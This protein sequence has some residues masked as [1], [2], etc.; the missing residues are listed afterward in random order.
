MTDIRTLKPFDGYIFKSFDVVDGF[1]YGYRNAHQY[2]RFGVDSDINTGNGWQ[3]TATFEALWN[4]DTGQ[5]L[6]STDFLIRGVFVFDGFAYC[7]V[8]ATAGADSGASSVFRFDVDGTNG[9]FVTRLGD[10]GGTWRTGVRLLS[11]NSMNEG[12][13]DGNA[14]IAFAEY[15]TNV[16]D[17]P[18]VGRVFY[19]N[20]S[21]ITDSVVGTVNVAVNFNETVVMISH[22]HGIQYNTLDSSWY[23]PCGDSD[24]QA[25]IIK[26]NG[27]A[28]WPSGASLTWATVGA[29]SG[30][31][32]LYSADQASPQWT[33]AI[34]MVF[35][36][37]FIY[38][39]VDENGASNQG[40]VR[41]RASDFDGLER[42][43]DNTLWATGFT[44][45]FTFEYQSRIFACSYW[46][47]NFAGA[48]DGYISFFSS[49]TGESGTWVEVGRWYI[50]SS[51]IIAVGGIALPSLL[52][53]SGDKLYFSSNGQA[54][55]SA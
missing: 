9:K 40:V 49:A 30:F 15:N 7:S 32:T 44:G 46:D 34:S 24:T 10:F 21:D 51:T 26:W 25:G 18:K 36:S 55:Q 6:V 22:V 13:I 8:E 31:T 12:V 29:T 41:V 50:G 54:K 19:I 35:R 43:M 5:A 2:A 38:W 52:K 23:V 53:S 42:V 48:A 14:V 17:T 20:K 45:W 27:T 33:R 37:D 47:T 3:D 4:A 16:V 28:T 1:L 39:T 11:D